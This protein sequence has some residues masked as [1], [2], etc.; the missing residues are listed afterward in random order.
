MLDVG[1]HIANY[2]VEAF[3]GSGGMSS[4]YRARHRALGSMHAIKVLDPE[5]GKESTLR[6]RFL[7]EG[8]VLAQVRHPG[9]VR[10]T[11]VVDEHGV[12]GLVMDLLQGEDL[13]RR[14]VQGPLPVDQAASIL[15]Q[16]LSAVGHA[17][18]A[19]VVHRDL[20]PANIFLVDRPGRTPLVKVLDFGI[21]KLEGSKATRATGTMGTAQY[22]SP[23]QIEDPRR[24]DAR[25]DLFSLG[26]VLFEMVAGQPAF[27]GETDYAIMRR[28][29]SGDHEVLPE[30]AGPLRDVVH[31]ALRPE[32]EARY[33]S[34]DA[35]AAAIAPMASPGVRAMVAEW[36]GEGTD[37]E[38]SRT[39]ER[40]AP[41][42]YQPD[43]SSS[44][45]RMPPAA[46]APP[47][48]LP[49]AA[50][51]SRPGRFDDAQV[52]RIAGMLQ[53]M[54]GTFN[55]LVMSAVQCFG[56]GMLGGL[57]ACFALILLS[58]GTVEILSG[59]V[60]IVRGSGRWVRTTAHLELLSIAGAG[61]LSAAVGL[62]VLGARRRYPTAIP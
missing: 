26:V 19:G 56:L 22:M 59:L 36:E 25:S 40:E 28:I 10:V 9:L 17:H 50:L 32:R 61:V 11:D 42:S 62:V 2:E 54:S 35:F 58:V 14:L 20:K 46:D 49:T 13:A 3:L 7:N 21:A 4:V 60:T 8:Q 53:L 39:S 12:A 27:T 37:V 57:P 16:V 29:V 55:V 51:Q 41:V 48:P 30:R 45:A 1:T 47:V 18:E 23:E 5:L 44:D 38:V 43:S 15:L 24:V 31:K 6:Q 34:A 33:A 52:V